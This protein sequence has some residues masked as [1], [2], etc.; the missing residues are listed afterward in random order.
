VANTVADSFGWLF[1]N[2]SPGFNESADATASNTPRNNLN[3][4][5]NGFP[6]G[7]QNTK[8]DYGLYQELSDRIVKFLKHELKVECQD[9]MILDKLFTK[10][11]MAFFLDQYWKHFNSVYPI[12][13]RA[14][15][16]DVTVKESQ[17]ELHLIFLSSMIS[18]GML[19]AP[20]NGDANIHYSVA[21]HIQKKMRLRLYQILDLTDYTVDTVPLSLLQ[22]LLLNDIFQMYFG[23]ANQLSKFSIYHSVVANIFKELRLFDNLVEPQI[24][25]QDLQNGKT[26]SWKTWVRYETLK[27]LTLFSYTLDTQGSFF[28]GLTPSV[29][30]FDIQ[31]EL[32]Y[33]DQLWNAEEPV[34]FSQSYKKLPRNLVTRPDHHSDYLQ[35]QKRYG[36]HDNIPDVI[37][38]NPMLPNVKPEGKW[39]NFL[40]SLRVMMQPLSNDDENL[41]YHFD[42]FSQFSRFVFLHGVLSLVKEL[43]SS[44]NMMM[45]GLR[46]PTFSSNRV[47]IL[48]AKIEKA[49]FC[50]RSYFHYNI[51]QANAVSLA[52]SKLGTILNVYD[53]SPMFWANI[54]LLNVGLLGLY[55]NFD[56]LVQFS[57]LIIEELS[58]TEVEHINHWSPGKI[59][60]DAIT[61]TKTRML[62]RS[63]SRSKDG[64]YSMNQACSLLR[65]VLNN[66]EII[67]SVPHLPYSLYL[68]LLV[69]W[70]YGF[71]T[72]IDENTETASLREDPK[73]CA[74]KFLDLF[75]LD[76]EENSSTEKEPNNDPPLLLLR[77]LIRYVT[78]SLLKYSQW[79]T[80]DSIFI[81]ELNVLVNVEL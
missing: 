39:P 20:L 9:E 3:F 69:C 52:K 80:D 14:T 1:G 28:Y 56:L 76:M 50:W 41:E 54:T 18:I 21:S 36:I 12:V 44:N 19:Y 81:D 53:T 26:E 70:S 33:P 67:T 72:Y 48:A 32:P 77:S 65:M 10:I 57:K 2:D 46:D 64:E 45:T 13:H 58:P 42:C 75:S 23:G 5:S 63:W 79:V 40:F 7:A 25:M 15:A 31:L 24:Q 6:S 66:E 11:S 47:N 17:T 35:S 8:A 55:C 71:N 4:N 49:F 27:R 34:S 22:S 16:F 43:R 74:F 73:E 29:S 37:P 60:F 68:A 30:V 78:K 38:G 59:R 61:N 51:T 62:V